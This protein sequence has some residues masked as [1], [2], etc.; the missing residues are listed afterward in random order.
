MSELLDKAVD[1]IRSKG[2]PRIAEGTTD[3]FERAVGSAKDWVRE[4]GATVLREP[5]LVVVAEEGLGKLAKA[6]PHVGHLAQS[7]AY[8][9]FDA[10]F[11]GD[12]EAARERFFRPSLTFA[13]R[14]EAQRRNSIS[15][16][17]D[18]LVDEREWD[19]LV[20]LLQDIGQ[21][22]LKAAIPFLLAAL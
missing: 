8:A 3:G 9:L 20:D 15:Y 17:Y 10:L 16:L 6:A 12:R 11:S 4:N 18:G 1:L 2:L 22:V 19:A 14:L 5:R 21:D 13:Q 7:Q